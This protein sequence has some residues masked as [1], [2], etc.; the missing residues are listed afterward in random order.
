VQPVVIT[1][2]LPAEAEL[3]LEDVKTSGTGTLR[4]FRTPPVAGGRDY[5]YHLEATWRE[6]TQTRTVQRSV[7]V[8]AGDEIEVDLHPD[9]ELTADEQAVFELLNKERQANGAPPLKVHPKLM[10][11]ARDHTLNM[12]RQNVLAH[13]LDGKS[14][15]DRVQAAG[16]NSFDLGENVAM[17]AR[18]ATDVVQMWMASPGHRAN[19]LNPRF[20]NLGIGR[21]VS[22]HGPCYHTLVFG[23]ALPER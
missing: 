12:A 8:R 4:R 22:E 19:I 10:R 2:R 3:K 11:A 21:C 16:Y 18:T 9:G 5:T 15:S 14:M 1:V 23:A 17:G 7:K 20:G 13:T 6:G